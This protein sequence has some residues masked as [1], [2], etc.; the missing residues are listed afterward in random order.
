MTNESRLVTLYSV[1]LLPSKKRN[2]VDYMI[3]DQITDESLLVTLYRVI[4]L[5]SNKRN[6]V[7][8]TIEEHIRHE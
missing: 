2:H 5:T 6:H 8:Y 7:H 3:D 1:I 4:L